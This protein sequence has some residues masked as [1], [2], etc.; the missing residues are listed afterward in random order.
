MRLED[1]ADGRRRGT[2]AA[3]EPREAAPSTAIEPSSGV[4]SAPIRFRI[5]LL[6]EPEAPGERDELARLDLERDVLSAGDPAA[7][8]RLAHAG[9]PTIAAPRLTAA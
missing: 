6:P 5:V 9:R 3:L 4:S 8:E 1:E 7:L 2:P